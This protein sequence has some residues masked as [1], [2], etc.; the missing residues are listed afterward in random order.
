MFTFERVLNDEEKTA[1][2]V[3]TESV[4]GYAANLTMS[5]LADGNEDVPLRNR[6]VIRINPKE[7]SCCLQYISIYKK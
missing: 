4:K 1:V 3:M 6:S 2:A 5:A 7:S